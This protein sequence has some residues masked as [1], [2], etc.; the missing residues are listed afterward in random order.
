MSDTLATFLTFLDVMCCEC[1][2]RKAMSA[3]D[4]KV[5][6]PQLLLHSKG[7]PLSNFAAGGLRVCCCLAGGVQS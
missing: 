5:L 6:Q 7:L 4:C 3:A 1:V 2:A